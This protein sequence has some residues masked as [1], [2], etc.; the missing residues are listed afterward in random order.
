MNGLPAGY[1]ARRIRVDDAD[2]LADF[3]NAYAEEVTGEAFATAERLRTMLAMPG[4]DLQTSSQ[5]IIGPDHCVAAAGIVMDFQPPHV[6]VGGWAYVAHQAQGLGIGAVLHEWLETRAREAMHK[7]PEGSRVVLQQNR[8]DEDSRAKTFLEQRGYRRCR[9]YWRM[10]ASLDCEPSKPVLPYKVSIRNLDLRRDAMLRDAME[11]FE[12]AFQDHHGYVEGNL[13]SRLAAMKYQVANDPRYTTE[14][15]FVAVD[16][17]EIAGA[18]LCSLNRE[19]NATQ[20]Y[21]NL[22]GV[23][24]SWRRRGIGLALLRNGFRVLRSLGTD[25]VTL[26]VDSQS[27]TSATRLY[28]RAGMEVDQL[29][30]TYEIELRSGEELRTRSIR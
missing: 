24:Q 10:V 26:H 30:H 6:E 4:L 19:A 7:A 17:S 18:C 21:V 23:R 11:V 3:I 14:L 28:E 29:S 27:L 8:T 13:E 5:V 25:C 2:R 20:G 22:L 9:S 16:G 12:E 15:S 1:S